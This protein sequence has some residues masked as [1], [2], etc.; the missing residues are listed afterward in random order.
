MTKPAI[1]ETLAPFIAKKLR[2]L[3]TSGEVK[4][5]EK[6]PTEKAL[7]ERFNVSRSVIREAYAG[8]RAEGLVEARRGAGV[9]AIAAPSQSSGQR[10]T[11]LGR[12]TYAVIEALEVRMAIEM[13]AAYLAAIRHS[14]HQEERIWDAVNTYKA[15]RD[16]CQDDIAADFDFHLAIAEATNNPRFVEFLKIFGENSIPRRSVIEVI[17]VEMSKDI[18][19]DIGQ[20]H[21]AIAA[22]IARR[23]PEQARHAMRLHLEHGQKRFRTF[24]RMGLVQD[25][26][27]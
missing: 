3:L 9:F 23:D 19:M 14:P 11:F 26:S 12:E 13:E 18:A 22:A 21:G 1:K 24:L 7:T 2:D 25:S 27:D 5:G 8:L 15:L 4:V 6:L 10:E 17:D 16:N 20:Q